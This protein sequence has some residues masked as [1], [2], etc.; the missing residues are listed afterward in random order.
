MPRLFG[1]R[2]SSGGMVVPWDLC[3]ASW[4]Y[5]LSFSAILLM[6]RECVF[7]SMFRKRNPMIGGPLPGS[8]LVF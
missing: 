8:S 4:S 7:P 6:K 2:G 1:G 3:I 5:E